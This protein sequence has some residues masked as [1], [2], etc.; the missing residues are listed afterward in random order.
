MSDTLLSLMKQYFGNFAD[1]AC[2]FE[3]LKPYVASLGDEELGS[4]VAFLK[5]QIS[6][7]DLSKK[8]EL[9]K[10]INAFKLQRF[11][12]TP[13]RS[14]A[15]ELGDVAVYLKAYFEGLPLGRRLILVRVSI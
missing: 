2:C 5:E 9:L 8:E 6:A 4:W 15:D 1:K 14:E 10:L 7:R 13:S 11:S 12:S 3:D